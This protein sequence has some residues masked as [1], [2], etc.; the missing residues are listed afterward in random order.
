VVVQEHTQQLVVTERVEHVD[1]HRCGGWRSASAVAAGL[2]AY[3]AGITLAG[4][5]AVA[6]TPKASCREVTLEGVS[7]AS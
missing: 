1:C 7:P 2:V 3:Y 5:C 4:V 6:D